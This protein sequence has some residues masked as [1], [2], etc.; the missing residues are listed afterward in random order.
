MQVLPIGVQDFVQIRQ[1]NMLYVDKTGRL[2]ELI[3]KGRRYFLSRPRRFGKS[4]MLSTLDAMFS[5]RCEVFKG[6]AAEK[7]VAKQADKPSPVLRFD[8][9]TRETG[10]SEILYKSL[11]TMLT[12]SGKKFN[13]ELTS[14]TVSDMFEELIEELHRQYGQVVVLIDEYDKPILDNLSDF[15]K[16]NEMREVLR[17][18]Y[19]VLKSCDEYLRFVMLTGISKFSK[20]GV[21]SAMNNLFDI[22]MME[23]YGDI[24]GYTQHDLEYNFSDWLN[25]IAAKRSSSREAIL[26]RLKDYYDGF[27]F[28]GKTRIYNPFSILNFFGTGEFDN[29]WYVSGSPSFMVEWMKE[30][31][32]QDPE[33]YRHILVNGD[34]IISAQEVEHA[35][36]PSFLLQSGYLTIEKR[37]GQLLTLDYPNKEVLNSLSSMYLRLVY[38]VKN[39]AGLGYEIWQ[40]LKVGDISRIVELYNT[41][42]ASIPYDD[43]AKNRN[44]YWYRAMFMMLLRGV[45]IITYAEIHTHKGRSDVLVQFKDVVVVFEF[46]YAAKS[47]EV[48][49]KKAEGAAQLQDREYTKGYDAEGCKVISAV[50][51]VDDEK[52]QVIF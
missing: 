48:D 18:F 17:T 1:D 46:K 12:R 21:F 14:D 23:Q 47:S 15:K 6:L 36:A 50:L 51:V 49:A 4:L 52:R 35:D 43:F 20:M 5:G 38:R 13:I 11:K 28:D 3:E 42:L 32:I 8:M 39:Y 7:W 30:H 9:S 10:T 16:A 45:G 27:S 41:A 33:E 24:A 2:Q 31:Q 19:T 25:K 34:F 22:S 37:E 40:A 44:E 26:A 29:Y